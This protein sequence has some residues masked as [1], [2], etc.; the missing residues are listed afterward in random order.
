MEDREDREIEVLLIEDHPAEAEKAIKILRKNKLATKLIHLRDG[1]EANDF[2]FCEGSFSQRNIH[3]QPKTIV[4][5]I[6]IPK[7]DDMEFLER[8]TLIFA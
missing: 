2:I 6:K 7:K 1:K 4:F 5:N 3:N 8:S